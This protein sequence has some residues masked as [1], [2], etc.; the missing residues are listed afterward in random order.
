MET[1][2][3]PTHHAPDYGC[4][5]SLPRGIFGLGMIGLCQHALTFRMRDKV[6]VT[7]EFVLGALAKATR[8]S[9]IFYYK[10]NAED[11]DKPAA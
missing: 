7:K 2:F 6:C 11:D 8:G 5:V 10:Y 9:S 3:L 4:Q 1:N